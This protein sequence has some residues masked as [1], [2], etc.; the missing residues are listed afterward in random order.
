MHAHGFDVL[1]ISSNGK[2]V[3]L[4]LQN[5]TCPHIIVPMTRRITPFRDIR[6]IIRLAL[7]F[8]KVKPDIVH[9]ESAKAGLLGM[10]AAYFSGVKVRIYTNAGL[11]MLAKRGFKLFLL[12]KVE[13]IIYAFATDIWPNGRSTMN[14]ILEH[15]YTKAKKVRLIGEGSSNG[16]DTVR[17]NRA[18]LD[19]EIS[20]DIKQSI[21][22]NPDNTYLLFVGRLVADKGITEFINVFLSL[23][24]HMPLIKLVLVGRYEKDLDPLP[25]HIEYEITHNPDIIQISWTGKVEYYMALANYFVFPSYREGFPNVIL[26]AAAMQVPVICSRIFGNIDMVTDGETG[27]IFERMNEAS[28]EEK[29]MQAF[30]DPGKMK[31]MALQLYENVVHLYKREIFWEEML[32]QYRALLPET[33]RNY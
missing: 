20:A 29:L 11:S 13:K 14:Y 1:M 33:D 7:I 31:T 18:D 8:R 25:A 16:V 32:K 22:Y 26:E 17:F 19:P 30:A 10:T 4:L 6:A 12:E 2:E 28:L 24:K 3:P 27:L 21:S 15:E 23:R 9:A 5:E